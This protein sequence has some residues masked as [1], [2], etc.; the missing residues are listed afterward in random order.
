VARD[1]LQAVDQNRFSVELR[2]F[3]A[4]RLALW[5]RV[6]EDAAFQGF[7]RVAGCCGPV[8]TRPA[9]WG[10]TLVRRGLHAVRRRRGS[11]FLDLGQRP[12]PNRGGCPLSLRIITGETGALRI[13]ERSSATL[14]QRVSRVHEH[15]WVVG[16][17]HGS[18]TLN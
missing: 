8:A 16:A 4:T 10:R 13:T 15:E 14:P 11:F 12:G 3:P 17:P 18:F 9:V 1:L 6:A 7:R 2:A 5:C